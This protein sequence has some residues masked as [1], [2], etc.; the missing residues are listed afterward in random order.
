M[1]EI[2]VMVSYLSQFLLELEVWWS[3]SAQFE[4]SENSQLLY[5]SSYLERTQVWI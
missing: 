2:C 3:E 1:V 5:M 4:I